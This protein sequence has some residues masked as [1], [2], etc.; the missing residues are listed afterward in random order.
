M[1][2]AK[3]CEQLLP[4]NFKNIYIIYKVPENK[5]ETIW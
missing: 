5:K 3:F 4:N 1:K 2:S